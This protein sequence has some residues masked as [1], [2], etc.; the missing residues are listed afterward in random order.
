MGSSVDDYYTILGLDAGA[1]RE[2]IKIAYRRL[3]RETH[4]DRKVQST[5]TDMS[6]FS[7]QMADLNQAYAVLSDIKQR[8][9]YDEKLRIQGILSS[10]KEAAKTAAREATLA[11]SVRTSPPVMVRPRHEVDPAVVREFSSHLRATFMADRQNFSWKEAE[12]DGFD[13]AIESVFWSTHYFVAARGSAS[14]N[15]AAAKKLID[16]AGMSIARYKRPIRKSYFLFL[17]PFQQLTEWESVSAQCQRFTSGAKRSKFS[18][19]GIVLLDMQH[20]RTLR[21]AHQIHEKRFAQLLQR[22]E[23]PT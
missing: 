4:P 16:Y 6:V 2:S 12:A 23:T 18:A 9:A 8:R 1:S 11:S 15:A 14:V 7:A 3:A 20:G 13:W 17:F 10:K 22:V 19:P 21:F 5:A